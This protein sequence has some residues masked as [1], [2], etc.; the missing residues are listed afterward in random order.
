M[1]TLKDPS[2]ELS[3]R[4]PRLGDRWRAGELLPAEFAARYFFHWQIAAHG[5]EFASRRHKQDA[6]PEA[7]ACL[8]ALE[9]AGGAERRAGM[10]DWLER[11]QFR[12]V[13]GSAPDALAR[14]LRGAWP[15][16]LR[17]DVPPALEVLRMQARGT[18]AV[19][20]IT[21][22]PRAAEPVLGKPDAFAFFL[23]DLEHAW[24]FFHSPELFAGQR[25]FFARLEAAVDRGVFA[26]RAE[27]AEFT[28][29]FHYLISDMN[30]HPEHSRQYLRA[31][32]I[33]HH[34]RLERLTGAERLS[35]AAERAIEE[36]MAEVDRPA[37]PVRV[38]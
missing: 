4:L 25:A 5:P 9:T 28:A 13:T 20:V 14:W 27:D 33:A 12:G 3:A 1:P 22:W 15:L 29:R 31:I 16:T 18:R 32:L 30:T 19:T 38:E 24:K 11:W 36:T 21:D 2:G 6:R 26:A 34:G 17:E 23:H 37:G 8:A 7:A 35:A 10:A